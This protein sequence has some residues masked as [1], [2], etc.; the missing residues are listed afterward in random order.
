MTNSCW[1]VNHPLQL[2]I[3]HCSESLLCARMSGMDVRNTDKESRQKGS[4]VPKKMD[5]IVY[6]VH[7]CVFLRAWKMVG[8]LLFVAS[9]F[10]SKMSNVG[11]LT[12]GH[13]KTFLKTLCLQTPYFKHLAFTE[14]LIN[15]VQQVQLHDRKRKSGSK[16]SNIAI[17]TL[18][19]HLF[20][21]IISW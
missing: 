10:K 16:S 13:G 20:W 19:Q 15:L 7:C 2:H 6:F 3:R 11:N 18:E 21:A 12:H 5:T 4:R 9:L 1:S 17:S 14:H 8:G